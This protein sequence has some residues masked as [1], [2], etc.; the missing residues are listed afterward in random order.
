[1]RCAA[2]PSYFDENE[3]HSFFRDWG[4]SLDVIIIFINW[5]AYISV[6]V[7]FEFMFSWP[8]FLIHLRVFRFMKPFH[9]SRAFHGMAHI[10]DNVLQAIPMLSNVLLLTALMIIMFAVLGLY[11]F[12]GALR[13]RC[14]VNEGYTFAQTYAASMLLAEPVRFC[15]MSGTRNLAWPCPSTM[16]CV[17]YGN[18]YG[19][20]LG[21]DHMGF[22]LTT[23]IT[24]VSL[25]GWVDLMYNLKEGSGSAPSLSFFIF[26]VIFFSQFILALMMAAL[27]DIFGSGARL[28][29]MRGALDAVEGEETLSAMR[30]NLNPALKTEAEDIEEGVY[31]PFDSIVEGVRGVDWLMAKGRGVHWTEHVELLDERLARQAEMQKNY[32]DA[33][34]KASEKA[35]DC[36]VYDLPVSDPLMKGLL[37][38]KAALTVVKLEVQGMTTNWDHLKWTVESWQF[39]Y[40]TYMLI[41]LS[42][43]AQTVDACVDSGSDVSWWAMLLDKIFCGMFILE[44]SLDVNLGFSLDNPL[45]VHQRKTLT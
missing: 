26:L 2:S 10:V 31:N 21:F 9:G 45:N 39:E 37:E 7:G 20:Y 6:A 16:I 25:E 32:D 13:G 34:A 27:S 38:S 15:D 5:L 30:T 19:G 41:L 4:N 11:M 1:M 43:V 23:V 18:P 29:T 8:V 40:L 12:N 3:P 17:D 14:V 44:V 42:I 28:R 33:Y 24:A 35:I 22:A 36:D